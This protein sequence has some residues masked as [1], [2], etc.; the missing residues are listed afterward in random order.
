MYNIFT[1]LFALAGAATQGGKMLSLC[2]VFQ[3]FPVFL[4]CTRHS[5]VFVGSCSLLA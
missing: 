4:V 5:D 1:C 2:V 3:C